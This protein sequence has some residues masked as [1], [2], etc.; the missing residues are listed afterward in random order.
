MYKQIISASNQKYKSWSKLSSKK[1]RDKQSKYII[2]GI[3]VIED[4]L[5]A[6]CEISAIIISSKLFDEMDK[7]KRCNDT[8]AEVMEIGSNGIYTNTDANIKINM[9]IK[10]IYSS[11]KN[12]YV[13][14]DALFNK[15]S[16]IQT[17]RGL[18]A[19]VEKHDWAISDIALKRPKSR[20]KNVLILDRLQD[21]G[22]LGT[23]I[24][25]VDAAGFAGIISIKGTVDLYSQKV[26]RAA[27]GSIFRV[28][29]V[30]VQSDE[31]AISLAREMGLKIVATSFD[32][33]VP[34]DSGVLAEATALIMGNEGSGVSEYVLNN[35]DALVKIDMHEGIDSLN[36]AVA[37]GILMYETQRCYRTKSD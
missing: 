8:R 17:S 13:L 21:P 22:N 30:K 12:V 16:D 29:V 6:C 11:K 5:R 25:T 18:I 2:E 20:L 9:F 34:Y 7:L 27:A 26:V 4:A 32:K 10:K 37:A 15:I 33:A 1:G 23:I 3:N 24:R 14:T 36:V 31:E 28:P 19:I 35:A